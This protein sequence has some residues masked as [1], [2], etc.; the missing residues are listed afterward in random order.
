MEGG[1]W[2]RWAQTNTL[3]ANYNLSNIHYVRHKPQFQLQKFPS[4]CWNRSI[5]ESINRPTSQPDKSNICWFELSTYKDLLLFPV[6][7]FFLKM[8]ATF[9]YTAA[10]T[11]FEDHLKKEL[12]AY[13]YHL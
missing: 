13:K 5:D 10:T 12:I 11:Q 1:N 9:C 8:T 7:F 3:N 4:D 2:H 6:F